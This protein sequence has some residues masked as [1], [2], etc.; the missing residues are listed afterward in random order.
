MHYLGIDPSTSSTGWAVLNE[1]GELVASGKLLA[2]ADN[3]VAFQHLYQEIWKLFAAYEPAAV[4]CETQF[5]G[6]NADTAIKLIRPTGVVLAVA[7]LYPESSF[8]FMKPS[9]W[10]K[11]YHAE[12]AYAKKYSK[13]NTF[14]LT[15]ERYPGVVTSFNKDNDIADAIGLAYACR[16]LSREE[17]SLEAR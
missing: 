13:R 2:E 7:G 16:S 6:Q 1:Q 8:Q 9:S 11:I 17:A 15:Q 3:P 12:T 10:R 14:A 5:M 4:V